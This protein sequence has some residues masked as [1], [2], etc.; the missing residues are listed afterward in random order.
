ME[1]KNKDIK[2][3]PTRITKRK[4]RR[5]LMSSFMTILYKC[6][7]G[8]GVIQGRGSFADRDLRYQGTTI[9]TAPPGENLGRECCIKKCNWCGAVWKKVPEGR[10]SA[11]P[12]FQ[13]FQIYVFPKFSIYGKIEILLMVPLSPYIHGPPSHVGVWFQFYI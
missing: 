6:S 2:L 4:Q 5:F 3:R 11:V 8:V 12:H 10:G 7:D 1:R 9:C 13:F